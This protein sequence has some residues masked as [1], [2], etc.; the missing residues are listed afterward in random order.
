LGVY[1]DTLEEVIYD[2]IENK[3]LDEE[4]FARKFARGKFRIKQ[5]GK[6]KITSM[7]KAKQVS[8]Y[9]IRKAMT[10][11]ED[12]DYDT[13]LRQVLEKEQRRLSLRVSNPY[14]MKQKLYA[15]AIRNGFESHLISEIL[16]DVMAGD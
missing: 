14:E 12:E 15:K 13:T 9:C 6:V 7:L 3:F 2:L 5:W 16:P 1:G 10:E 8:A 11:I 4:R